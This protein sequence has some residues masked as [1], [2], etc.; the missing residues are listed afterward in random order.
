MPW[1]LSSRG[2]VGGASSSRVAVL[3][4]WRCICCTPCGPCGAGAATGAAGARA[5]SA[6]LGGRCSF[7]AALVLYLPLEVGRGQPPHQIGG[8][9]LVEQRDY[10]GGPRGRRV[11][12]PP[13]PG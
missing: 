12:G 6:G 1:P 4:I 9:P 7:G 3:P 11:A 5:G 8:L 13:Q 2:S 10:L